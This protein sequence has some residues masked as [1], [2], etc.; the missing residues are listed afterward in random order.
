MRFGR[1]GA[2]FPL[3]GQGQWEKKGGMDEGRGGLEVLMQVEGLI[4]RI[5]SDTAFVFAVKIQVTD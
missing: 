3:V 5:E 2:L 1:E 4:R